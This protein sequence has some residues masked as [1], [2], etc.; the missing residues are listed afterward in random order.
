LGPEKEKRTIRFAFIIFIVLVIFSVGQLTWWIIFQIDTGRKQKQFQMD[1]VNQEIAYLAHHINRDFQ[2]FIDIALLMQG[3]LPGQSPR[4]KEF[5]DKLLDNPAVAG[6]LITDAEGR[7]LYRGGEVDSTFYAAPGKG[8]LLFFNKNYPGQIIKTHKADLDFRVEGFHDGREAPWVTE[9]MFHVPPEVTA[10]LESGLHRRIVMFVSEGSFFMLLILFGAYLIYRAL[11]HSEDLK[12]RQQNFIQAVTHEF[13]TPMTSM[14]LYL[15]TLKSGKVQPEKTGELYPKMLDD[16]DRL[17]RLVD[18][19][20]QAS[21]YN[22][23]DY[24]LNLAETDLAED[25]ND[26][27]NNL[28]PLVKRHNGELRRDLEPGLRVRTD[29]QSLGRAVTALVDNALKYSPTDKRQIDVTLHKDADR[30][31]LRVADHGSGIPAAE[32]ERIFE[33]FYRVGN[34]T[35]RTVKGTGL[36]LYLVR[37]IVE[38]HGGEVRVTS[39]G[40]GPGSVFTI[41]LPM[42]NG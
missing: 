6:Y 36:G 31:E 1:Y 13:R 42:V 18:N 37:Q 41:K 22:Q 39:N 32:R 25:V 28:E 23:D 29:Y 8:I 10:R 21:L 40:T 16:C 11:R 9:A 30:A 17:D 26:Y 5:F 19:V 34:E 7:T 12:L 2:S 15:E 27:L 3:S 38:A 4:L 20:L 33:R 24:R 35:T 14:R